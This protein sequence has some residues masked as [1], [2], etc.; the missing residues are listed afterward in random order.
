MLKDIDFRKVEDTAMAIIRETAEGEKTW[1]AYL[2]NTGQDIIKSILVSSKGYGEIDG[3]PVKTSELRQ[4]IE[5][6]DPGAFIRVEE[7]RAEL[8]PLNNEFWISF[9]KGDYLFDKKYVF[10]TETIRTDNFVQVPHIDK[11]GVLIK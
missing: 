1:N 3:Q 5:S 4:F 7:I 10:L 2:I 11:P 8:L 9:T 6:M